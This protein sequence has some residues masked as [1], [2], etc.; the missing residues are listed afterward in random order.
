MSFISTLIHAHIRSH[1]TSMGLL[2]NG[3]GISAYVNPP[4]G[5]V[6]HQGPNDSKPRK[7]GPTA[8]VRKAMFESDHG[9]PSIVLVFPL[10]KWELMLMNGLKSDRVEV[11]NYGDVKWHAIED[12]LPGKGTGRHIAGFILKAPRYEPVGIAR[13]G[14]NLSDTGQRD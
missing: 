12:N 11:R 10:S 4:F 2:L 5:S 14:N 1:Q 7:K 8:W 6:W 13:V 3:G 9:Y